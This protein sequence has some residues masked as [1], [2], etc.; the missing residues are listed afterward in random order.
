[1]LQFAADARELA[2]NIYSEA[3]IYSSIEAR[4]FMSSILTA[5]PRLFAQAEAFDRAETA[6]VPNETEFN[7]ISE[8]RTY[9][10]SVA[11][12]RPASNAC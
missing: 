9:I 2:I 12:D 7:G 11:G 5:P 4:T 8:L 3:N 10:G 1:L 6:A